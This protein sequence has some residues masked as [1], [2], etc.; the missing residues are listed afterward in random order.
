MGVLLL[1]TEGIL[2][3]AHRRTTGLGIQNGPQESHSPVVLKLFEMRE[4]LLSPMDSFVEC[5]WV[6]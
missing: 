5:R 1:T 4:T 6:T 3:D 2:K